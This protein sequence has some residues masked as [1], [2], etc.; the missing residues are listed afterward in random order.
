MVVPQPRRNLT[1]NRAPTTA[2]NSCTC[3]G[4]RMMHSAADVAPVK[5]K[6]PCPTLADLHSGRC[7]SQ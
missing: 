6:L 1:P 4:I 7:H 3:P 2:A 5:L